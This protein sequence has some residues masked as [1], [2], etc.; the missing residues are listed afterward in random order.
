MLAIRDAWTCSDGKLCVRL[1][2][3]FLAEWP[4]SSLSFVCSSVP[5]RRRWQQQQLNGEQVRRT[6]V[7][8]LF[9]SC[10]VVVSKETGSCCHAVK[11]MPRERKRDDDEET[12][13]NTHF[14]LPLRT[15]WLWLNFFLFFFWELINYAAVV[16]V[17]GT[18]PYVFFYFKVMSA[19][20]GSR[21]IIFICVC[22]LHAMMDY[23]RHLSHP[24]PFQEVFKIRFFTVL[25]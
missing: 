9:P 6:F 12:R 7:A 16:F 1:L 14:L 10:F 15:P 22:S 13:A 20:L 19:V 3:L 2:F 21:A 8:R 17:V 18:V 24:F 25:G 5:K 23:I 4:S 11:D